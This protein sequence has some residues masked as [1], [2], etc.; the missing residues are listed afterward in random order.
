MS[1]PVPLFLVNRRL[2]RTYFVFRFIFEVVHSADLPWVYGGEY[3]QL[4]QLVR[5]VVHAWIEVGLDLHFVFDGEY[6]SS[7]WLRKSI[8]SPGYPAARCLS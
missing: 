6:S 2:Q 3:T 8:L 4:S 7:F 5:Q 1:L